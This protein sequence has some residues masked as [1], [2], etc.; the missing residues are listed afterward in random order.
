[1]AWQL[2]PR[3]FTLILLTSLRSHFV[4]LIL[5]FSFCSALLHVAQVLAHIR[6]VCPSAEFVGLFCA[7]LLE[8]VVWSAVEGL[9]SLQEA[10]AVSGI[11]DSDLC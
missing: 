9:Q 6:S 8:C 10:G 3:S 7:L 4:A 2:P 1:M 5:S 11:R